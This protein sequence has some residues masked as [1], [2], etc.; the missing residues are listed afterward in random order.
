MLQKRCEVPCSEGT[1]GSVEHVQTLLLHTHIKLK[2]WF[3]SI[4]KTQIVDPWIVQQI[5][6]AAHNYIIANFIHP[7]VLEY[8]YLIGLF[9]LFRPTPT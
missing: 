3:I 9:L 2:Q 1:E 7:V 5:T 4:K 8:P 6:S